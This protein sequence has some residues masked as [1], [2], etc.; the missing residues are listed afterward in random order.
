MQKYNSM[1]IDIQDKQD[2]FDVSR[3]LISKICALVLTAEKQD[4][5]FELS[6]LFIDNSEMK[7][8]NSTYRHIDSP[9]DVL[10]FPMNEEQTFS[11]LDRMLGDIVISTEQAIKQ[12]DEQGHRPVKEIIIL[13]IHGLLHLLGYDHLEE[14]EQNEMKSRE[15]LYLK[16]SLEYI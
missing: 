13:I 10:A 11:E 8:L 14:G 1:I 3:E 15:D 16:K 6:F 2:F 7:K 5:N 12:A 4:S 9:T